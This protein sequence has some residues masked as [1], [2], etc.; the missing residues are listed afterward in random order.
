MIVLLQTRT[1]RD[2]ILELYQ[3]AN[4]R[5]SDVTHRNVLFLAEK[6]NEVRP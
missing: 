1:R 3:I 4:K 6:G 5:S 2:F